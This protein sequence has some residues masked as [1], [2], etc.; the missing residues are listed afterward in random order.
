MQNE[1]KY[2]GLLWNSLYTAVVLW[3]CVQISSKCYDY[4]EFPF[5]KG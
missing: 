4:N 5:L 1:I 2:L 3:W